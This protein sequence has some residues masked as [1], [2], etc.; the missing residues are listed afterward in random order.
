[1]LNVIQGFCSCTD[2]LL[3]T[4]KQNTTLQIQSEWKTVDKFTEF[5][6][7][8]GDENKGERTKE[9][10]NDD[11]LDRPGSVLIGLR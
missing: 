7:F 10:E 2:L 5:I 8:L 11:E 3:F 9:L 4:I 1:M 6:Y